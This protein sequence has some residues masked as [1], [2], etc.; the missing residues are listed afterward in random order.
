MRRASAGSSVRWAR[1]PSVED[2]GRDDY[3]EVGNP[4]T[5][6]LELRYFDPPLM[7]VHISGLTI[8]DDDGESEYLSAL[9]MM[10]KEVYFSDPPDITKYIGP[11]DPWF[12]INL[13]TPP[14]YSIHTMQ[15]VHKDW[16]G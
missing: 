3:F 14:K 11:A 8:S 15:V 9:V 13:H 12:N 4:V 7:C 6:V 16:C 2:I 10:E 5:R 1:T